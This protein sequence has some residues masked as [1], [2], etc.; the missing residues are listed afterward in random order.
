MQD[1][2]WRQ[3]LEPGIDQAVL[4]VMRPFAVD[5]DAHIEYLRFDVSAI[6]PGEERMF[7]IDGMPVVFYREAVA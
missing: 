6:G 5:V 1:T 7:L 4:P 3:R 2:I